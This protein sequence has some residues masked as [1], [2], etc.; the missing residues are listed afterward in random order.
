MPIRGG[1]GGGGQVHVRK[2]EEEEEEEEKAEEEALDHMKK[3]SMPILRGLTNL[4]ARKKGE[5]EIE[6][7][8]GQI[9]MANSVGILNLIPNHRR[10]SPRSQ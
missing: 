5:I 9:A 4:G 6:R 3:V 7:G 2:P 8:D 1:G 10:K